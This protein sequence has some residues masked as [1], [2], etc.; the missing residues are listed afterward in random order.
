MH[1]QRPS[2]HSNSHSNIHNNSHSSNRCSSR[3][4]WQRP[5]LQLLRLVGSQK[6][7]VIQV[8]VSRLLTRQD[9]AHGQV[10][11]LAKGNHNGV[12][13]HDSCSVLCILIWLYHIVSQTTVSYTTVSTYHI[14]PCA[15]IGYICCSR[16]HFAC[17]VLLPPLPAPRTA[18]AQA[19][20][21]ADPRSSEVALGRACRGLRDMVFECNGDRQRGRE[22]EGGERGLI[23]WYLGLNYYSFC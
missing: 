2:N 14:Q 6:C 3:R 11:A 16:A 17:V 23:N 22:R 20:A 19:Q 10:Q 12:Y 5:S 21:E 13:H 15:I 4:R 8:S 1:P 18:K 7:S 9:E